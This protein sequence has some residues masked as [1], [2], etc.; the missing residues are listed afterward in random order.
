MTSATYAFARAYELPIRRVI[1][2]PASA[3]PDAD[4]SAAETTEQGLPYTGDG[5]L[6]N[7][8]PDF[9]GMPNREALR[10]DRG[11]AGCEGKGHAVG[12]TTVCAT[13]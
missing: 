12:Q 6:V 1:E 3:A 13:G 7:S 5:L 10:R 8:H 2:G 11:V 4:P 9:D